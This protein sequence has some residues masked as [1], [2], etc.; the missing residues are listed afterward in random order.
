[1]ISLRLSSGIVKRLLIVTSLLLSFISAVNAQV[2]DVHRIAMEE[3]IHEYLGRIKDKSK[4]TSRSAIDSL[5]GANIELMAYLRN[6]CKLY[7]GLIGE[8]FVTVGDIDG[9]LYGMNIV[10][11]EDKAL[12]IYCWDSW[13]SKDMH[14]FNSLVQYRLGTE[15]I[16]L[17][18]SDVAERKGRIG[19]ALN[20]FAEI[21]T[22][23]DKDN[24]PIYLVMSFRISQEN[25]GGHELQAFR[26]DSSLAPVAVFNYYGDL[27]N[28]LVVYNDRS[29]R[30]RW[31]EDDTNIKISADG[32]TVYVPVVKSGNPNKKVT[33]NEKNYHIYQ[34]N[35]SEFVYKENLNN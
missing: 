25:E 29:V 21:N 33:G 1:M 19:K 3:T 2:L 10:S 27:K 31:S 20:C 17:P 6:M 16:T 32:K 24:R 30:G 14:R 4:D 22:V 15:I 8:E 9:Q 13:T 18:W 12:R 23:I 7:P 5:W 34:F 26:I 28:S 11:S 35:G